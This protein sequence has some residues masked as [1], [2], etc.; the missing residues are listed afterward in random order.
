MRYEKRNRELNI[1]NKYLRR[2]KNSRGGLSGVFD[3]PIFLKNW[4]VI[5]VIS[6]CD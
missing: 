6:S 1:E 2:E 4:E 3:P 5:D